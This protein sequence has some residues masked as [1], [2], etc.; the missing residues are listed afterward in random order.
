VSPVSVGAYC[1][2]TQ[3]RQIELI[4]RRI[5]FARALGGD[6]TSSATRRASSRSTP[7]NGGSWSTRCATWVTT[8]A[9]QGVRIAPGDARRTDSE[10]DA[11]FAAFSTQST[12][13]PL[14]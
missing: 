4:K 9:D 7:S 1:D 6:T 11:G 13:R 8:A 14:A 3:A 12:I 10:R 5:D 2:L